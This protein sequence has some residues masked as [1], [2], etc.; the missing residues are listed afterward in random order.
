MNESD[1][2]FELLRETDQR[3]HNF[4]PNLD[5]GSLNLGCG[6]KDGP[7]LH[8]RNFRV[9]NAQ[10]ATAV[11]EHRIEF[12]QFFNTAG[13]AVGG[14]SEFFGQIPLGCF[15][16]G[17]E[18][19]E[20]RIEEADGGG[21]AFQRLENPCEIGALGGQ[22]FGQGFAPFICIFR[23]NH[24]AD[25]VDTVS[26]KE[27]VFRAA[28]SDALGSEGDCVSHLV[29]LVGVGADFK[30]PALICPLHQLG[31][32]AVDGAFGWGQIFVDQDADNIGGRGFHLPGEDFPRGAID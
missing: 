4:R 12:M 13:D 19:M 20:G 26:L 29:R 11:A 3:N 14:D 9:N 21:Q 28:E 8:F 6:F 18:L 7:R 16:V 5:S 25:M 30:F 17:D 31:E 22:K 2:E 27:H 23:Q 15:I 24:F 10:A 32:H 1:L